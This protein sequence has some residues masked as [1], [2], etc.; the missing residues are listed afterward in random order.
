MVESLGETVADVLLRPTTIYV[1]AMRKI[2][3][4]YRVK[5]PVHGIAH[6]TGGGLHENLARIVPDGVQLRINRDS[7]PIPPAF[8]WLRQLGDLDLEEMFR[9][10]N[11][12]L[13]LVLIVSPTHASVIQG[14]VESAGLSCF[15]I[16]EVHEAATG[17]EKTAWND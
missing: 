4:H 13:G 5:R 17:A 1:P 2:W 15:P 12:G 7:W 9:V 10:F 11:M 3:G 14:L 6:I 16:G 8:D